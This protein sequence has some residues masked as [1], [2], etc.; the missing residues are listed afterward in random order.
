MNTRLE[1]KK[2]NLLINDMVRAI[3]SW[4]QPTE[5]DFYDEKEILEYNSLVTIIES[6]LRKHKLLDFIKNNIEFDGS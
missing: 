5:K 3:M 6:I 2:T 4:K 1:Y